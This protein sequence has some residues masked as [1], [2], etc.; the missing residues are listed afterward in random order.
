ME[1][2]PCVR[3]FFQVFG[4]IGPIRVG[5]SVRTA[6]Q[7]AAQAEWNSIPPRRQ[8]RR[9]PRRPLISDR[10]AGSRTGRVE[11]HSAAQA[12]AQAVQ[13][14]FQSQSRLNFEAGPARAPLP[15]HAAPYFL[16]VFFS[17][18]RL[19]VFNFNFLIQDGLGWV[20]A[21]WL[22]LAGWL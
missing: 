13:I 22:A 5:C 2:F 12:A 9:Q 21:L 16:K 10:R 6:S 18:F 17:K 19:P 20:G 1:V 3:K 15:H 4:R 11:F 7:A 8:P 14:N